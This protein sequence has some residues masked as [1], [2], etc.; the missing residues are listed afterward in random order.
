[1]G[2]WT[3]TLSSLTAEPDA[4]T[5]RLGS[6]IYKAHGTLTATLVDQQTD[7]GDASVSLSLTF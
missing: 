1:M 2:S 7:G 6:V 3:V 4:G 5:G